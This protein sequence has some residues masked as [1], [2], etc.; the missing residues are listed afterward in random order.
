MGTIV[1]R[2][3]RIPATQKSSMRP[4]HGGSITALAALVL[5]S[6][7]LTIGGGTPAA[8]ASKGSPPG[9]SYFPNVP[10]VTQDGKAVRFY[11]DLLKD[12]NVVISTFSTHCAPCLPV[13]EVLVQ[14]QRFL[15]DR[16]GRDI[17]IYSITSDPERDT[18]EALREYAEKLH[19]GP[20]WL[21]LTGRRAEI[22]L[23]GKKLGLHAT[24]DASDPV[25]HTS[26]V[27]IGNEV[28][29]QWRWHSAVDNPQFLAVMFDAYL[30]SNA[31]RQPGRSY[32]ETAPLTAKGQY[33]F[34]TRCVVCHT[35]GQGDG[36]GP[37]LQGVTARRDRTWLARWLAAPDR[38]LA[39]GDPTAMTLFAKYQN[40]EMPNLNL[41][42]RDVA[43]LL[44]Y[45]EKQ[46]ADR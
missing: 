27:V 28:T 2:P 42:E 39:E 45:L 18:P 7:L 37:D 36:D 34:A 9:A 23:L 29:R 40:T 13:A 8:A 32:A 5:S 19:A 30:P 31:P 24:R 4:P 14:V 33:L 3:C 10:L 41:S 6:M 46:S 15:G 26:K 11:D 22:D 17:F 12:K 21:F 16:V 38:V 43:A 1:S 25:A 35:I 44:G 20:G